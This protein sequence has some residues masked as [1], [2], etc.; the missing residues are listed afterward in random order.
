ML[1]GYQRTTMQG[2]GCGLTPCESCSRG[3]GDLLDPSTWGPA[4]WLVAVAAGWIG[5]KLFTAGKE[6][7]YSRIVRRRLGAEA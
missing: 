2:L 3:M 6:R 7:R 5:Y 1:S 4:D